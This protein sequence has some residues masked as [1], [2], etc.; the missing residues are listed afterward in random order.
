MTSYM[1]NYPAPGFADVDSYS[2]PGLPYV[3]SSTVSTIT[4]NHTF[5]YVTK[6][7]YIKNNGP[8][9]LQVGFT[10]V[11]TSGSNYFLVT[12]GSEA[13]F[14]TR[15]KQLN[16]VTLTATSNYSLFVGLTGIPAK[17]MPTLTSSTNS[18]SFGWPY[19]G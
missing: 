9:N 6:H 7:I 15:V 1:K 13:K 3:T 19:A 10:A 18:G 2:V 8:A 4:K 17:N 11:G 16:L 14:E 12:S 5:D